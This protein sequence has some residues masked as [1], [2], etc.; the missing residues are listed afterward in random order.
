VNIRS[1]TRTAV[2]GPR[3]RAGT[4]AGSDAADAGIVGSR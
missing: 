1:I 3:E 2:S 4:I